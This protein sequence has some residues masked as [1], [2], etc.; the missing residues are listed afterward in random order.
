MQWRYL[1]LQP[2]SL[3]D[4]YASNWLPGSFMVLSGTQ[5]LWKAW[6]RGV[7]P[8]KGSKWT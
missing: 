3:Q 1:V 7:Q 5:V 2:F 8:D 6:R 4:C